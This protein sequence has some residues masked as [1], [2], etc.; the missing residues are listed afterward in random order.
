MVQIFTKGELIA[1]HILTE[2]GKRTE[3][4]HYPPEKIAFHMRTPSWCHTA[5]A[6]S[7]PRPWQ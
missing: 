2:R 5:R 3:I 1:S 4:G 6:R 7:A